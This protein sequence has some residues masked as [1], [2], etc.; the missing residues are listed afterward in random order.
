M[1]T[2]PTSLT[3]KQA[4]ELTALLKE[5]RKFLRDAAGSRIYSPNY[6]SASSRI[7]DVLREFDVDPG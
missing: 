6:A 2:L 1:E 5:A 4:A 7:A 3:T